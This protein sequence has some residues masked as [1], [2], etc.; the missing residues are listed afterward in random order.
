[1]LPSSPVPNL[2]SSKEGQKRLIRAEKGARAEVGP[3]R[4]HG[5]LWPSSLLHTEKAASVK[6]ISLSCE[7]ILK[8]FR[9]LAKA[10]NG[11]GGRPMTD[12][13]RYWEIFE[14]FW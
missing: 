8:N 11:F 6:T 7:R 12:L 4:Q 2:D 13:E 14:S 1:M 3:A 9:K 10:A 5:H